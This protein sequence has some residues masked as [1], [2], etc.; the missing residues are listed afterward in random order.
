MKK[1]REIRL[2]PKRKSFFRG[3]YSYNPIIDK[4]YVRSFMET[5]ARC[6]LYFNEGE[7]NIGVLCGHR[8]RLYRLGAEARRILIRAGRRRG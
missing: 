5:A 6:S 2:Y 8:A 4:W 7:R 1:E 3:A